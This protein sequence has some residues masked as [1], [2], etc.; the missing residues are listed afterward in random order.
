MIYIQIIATASINSIFS[1]KKENEYEDFENLKNSQ[2]NID[3]A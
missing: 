3:R 1:N 2:N